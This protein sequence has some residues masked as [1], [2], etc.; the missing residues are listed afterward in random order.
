MWRKEKQLGFPVQFTHDDQGVEWIL[1][2]E[3]YSINEH[4]PFH[5]T[6]E[7]RKAPSW[8]ESCTN[9][10]YQFRMPT[11]CFTPSTAVKSPTY[12]VAITKKVCA[13]FECR[14]GKFQTCLH[15]DDIGAHVVG[16][17]CGREYYQ[18]PPP[19]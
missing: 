17:V 18:W 13:C 19:E 5:Q 4:L 11:E 14:S 9:S 8:I 6:T 10:N 7:K 12:E 1:L 15:R 3:H 16:K 2:D